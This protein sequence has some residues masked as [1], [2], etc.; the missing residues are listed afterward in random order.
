MDLLAASVIDHMENR[1][2]N[3]T[4]V[5]TVLEKIV[6]R[7]ANWNRRRHRQVA[8]LRKRATEVNQRLQRLYLP[9]SKA[10]PTR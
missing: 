2:L 5:M 10:S 7:R 6:E 4:R 9:S 8:D 1:L 3:P